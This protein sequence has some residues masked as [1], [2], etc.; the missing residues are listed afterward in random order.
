M[1]GGER[2]VR[3]VFDQREA[4]VVVA[5]VA[6]ANARRNDGLGPGA[7][8]GILGGA[9]LD[10]REGSRVETFRDRATLALRY[11]I[12]QARKPRLLLFQ[13]LPAHC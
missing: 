11:V 8:A 10:R 9:R 12:R 4:V 7:M 3:F 2:L 13:L 6:K 5:V 1:Q